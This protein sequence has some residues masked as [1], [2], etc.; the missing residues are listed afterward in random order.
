MDANTKS[1]P[2]PTPVN[3]SSIFSSQK[4]GR[5]ARR[6]VEGMALL[7]LVFAACAAALWWLAPV[8]PQ[9]P[10]GADLARLAHARGV[11]DLPT[12][13]ASLSTFSQM[14]SS[15]GDILPVH[16]KRYARVAQVHAWVG[17][18]AL[19]TL[20]GLVSMRV[21]RWLSWR[22][23]I[24]LA[25]LGLSPAMWWSLVNPTDFQAGLICALFAWCVWE[26]AAKSKRSSWGAG[27]VGFAMSQTWVIWPWA[28]LIA[29]D[30]TR[31]Q[32]EAERRNFTL[33]G[34]MGFVGPALVGWVADPSGA[35]RAAFP[36]L[37][38]FKML[39]AEDLLAAGELLV[40]G[41]GEARLA[42]WAG[43]PLALL[44][45]SL[46]EPLRGTRVQSSMRGLGV[47]LVAVPILSLLTQL[48][49]A[50]SAWKLAWPGYNTVLVDAARNTYRVLPSVALVVVDSITEEAM[51][52]Y[53]RADLIR[54]DQEGQARPGD[55]PKTATA[56]AVL[57]VDR[58]SDE[59]ERARL[60]Q[61]WTRFQFNEQA[62]QGSGRKLDLVRDVF[63][64]NLRLSEKADAP[65]PQ[66]VRTIWTPRLLPLDEEQRAELDAV[67][68]GFG[69]AY[70]LGKG[71][72]GVDLES[73]AKISVE[74]HLAREERLSSESVE[75]AVFERY[76]DL[77][78][79]FARR[80]QEVGTGTL[81]DVAVSS[82]LA[83]LD[84]VPWNLPALEFVCN[85][86]HQHPRLTEAVRKQHC[87]L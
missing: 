26:F 11:S 4:S 51:L 6:A 43:A 73:M 85:P 74:T 9:G 24:W 84:R 27:F 86:Q 87:D 21:L 80:T 32:A 34:L 25:V 46:T 33:Y 62:Y 48:V 2:T 23:A 13:P 16:G 7:L 59:V 44:W 69:V 30:F 17:L 83:V 52:A 38:P 15:L 64:P 10:L 18:I 35:T 76:A 77:P 31:S 66:G 42:L 8:T 45:A 36:V 49:R 79:A 57:R 61:A 47:L 63:L 3:R 1:S 50:P 55:Q 39:M 28:L 81:S 60:R 82:W 68:L 70:K 37:I 22:D 5:G 40:G 19:L 58:L 20:I 71:Q 14:L 29:R 67:Q 65:E 78:L 56:T 54:V 75:F 41:G 72:A 53:Q 12:L